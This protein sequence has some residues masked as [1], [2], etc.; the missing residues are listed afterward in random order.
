M[1]FGVLH[2][3]G[4]LSSRVLL[5]CSDDILRIA[6]MGVGVGWDLLLVMWQKVWSFGLKLDRVG[7]LIEVVDFADLFEC[8]CRHFGVQCILIPHTSL[9]YGG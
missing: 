9:C 2:T 5:V 6:W 7:V 1:A 8:C 4:G 3:C